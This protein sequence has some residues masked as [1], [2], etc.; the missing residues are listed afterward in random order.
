VEII[1]DVDGR[2]RVLS[3]PQAPT[4]A[5]EVG[6]FSKE[7]RSAGVR[8]VEPLEYTHFSGAQFEKLVKKKPQQALDMLF[9]AARV[10][11]CLIIQKNVA[12]TGG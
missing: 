11:V 12:Q 6:F 3:R 8:A 5:G 1:Q 4:I 10:I 7:K 2:T 9:A